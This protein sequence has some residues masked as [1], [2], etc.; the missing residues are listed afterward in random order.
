M[1]WDWPSLLT[2]QERSVAM[3]ANR[4]WKY[5]RLGDK[6]RKMYICMPRRNDVFLKQ[7]EPSSSRSLYL[8]NFIMSVSWTRKTTWVGQPKHFEVVEKCSCTL[9]VILIA[10]LYHVNCLPHSSYVSR[11]LS[12]LVKIST[13]LSNIREYWIAFVL[14]QRAPPLLLTSITATDYLFTSRN[15]EFNV[16]LSNKT[17]LNHLIITI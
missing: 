11:L 15:G 7:I 9:S 16:S 14:F 1:F 10:V 4:K 2:V 6:L 5:T 12:V 13:E 3:L 17:A 8:G